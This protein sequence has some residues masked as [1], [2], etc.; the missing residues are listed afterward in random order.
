MEKK[1]IL[2]FEWEQEKEK[3]QLNVESS[4]Y[5]NLYIG[6]DAQQPEG[7]EYFDDLTVNLPYAPHKANVAYI[8]PNCSEEKIRFI[9]KYGL[10][11]VLG[12]MAYSRYCTFKKVAFDME[13]LRE[14]DP[15]GVDSFLRMHPELQKGKKQKSTEKKM[16][17]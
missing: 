17:R 12:E 8:D 1:P 14:M 13:R 15:R 2:D 7:M 11:K 4:M 5:G 10:G 9:Q 16:E 3:I 6:M